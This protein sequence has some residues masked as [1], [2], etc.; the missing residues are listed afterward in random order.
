MKKTDQVA[1]REILKWGGIGLA[2]ISSAGLW[3]KGLATMCASTPKQPEGP[4]YPVSQQQDT[5]T[6]L[7]KVLG[8]NKLADGQIIF[9]QGKIMDQ[10]CQSVENAVVEIW[11]AC[12]SGRYNHP[13]D[14]DN[15]NKLDENF[16][17]WG[18]AVSDNRG[19][20]NFKTIIPGAYVAG[21]GWM[22]PPH[23]HF[24]I[25]KRGYQDLITQMYFEGN[26]YNENDRILRA[27]PKS[28]WPAVVRPL[29]AKNSQNGRECF[30]VNFDISIQKIT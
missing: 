14:I 22:R 26:Q 13:G 11:Q 3:A 8:R 16:Q 17:Y 27:L 23:I 12:A 21:P 1:R 10:Y 2:S 9:L 19:D 4:F 30:D 25:Y 7:T 20:Y 24:K 5:D 18:I 29:T 15:K 6:D 28:E